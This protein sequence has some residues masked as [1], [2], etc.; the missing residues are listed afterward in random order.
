[1]CACVILCGGQWSC[2]G[3]AVRSGMQPRIHELDGALGLDGG[4]GRIHI[5]WHNIAAWAVKACQ[6]IPSEYR[7]HQGSCSCFAN[8]C[9]LL[10]SVACTS[11]NLKLW[12]HNAGHPRGTSCS[13][14]CTSRD[15]DHT[16]YY[17]LVVAATTYLSP[18]RGLEAKGTCMPCMMMIGCRYETALSPKPQVTPDVAHILA[19]AVIGRDSAS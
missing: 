3:N 18:K 7:G 2:M 10:H 5:L 16:C 12:L 1:M 4:H 8:L 14:P 9:T 17:Y 19:L 15:E 11:V 13:R 6:N